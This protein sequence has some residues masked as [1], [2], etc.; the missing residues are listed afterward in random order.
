MG[1]LLR[2]LFPAHHWQCILPLFLQ[3]AHALLGSKSLPINRSF[4]PK[5]SQPLCFLYDRPP[6]PSILP[7]QML[8]TRMR[9]ASGPTTKRRKTGFR[10]TTSSTDMWTGFAMAGCSERDTSLLEIAARIVGI[11]RMAMMCNESS[12]CTAMVCCLKF[13]TTTVE[14]ALDLLGSR[15]ACRSASLVGGPGRGVAAGDGQRED[16][17]DGRRR[18]AAAPLDKGERQPPVLGIP[19]KFV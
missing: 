3:L 11:E 1:G 16:P 4:C 15:D 13:F 18:P 12:G 8:K 10:T 17:G 7:P 14:D 2:R 6:N 5:C 19:P 9:S